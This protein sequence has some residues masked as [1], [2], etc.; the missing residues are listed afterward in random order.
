[1]APTSARPCGPDHYPVDDADTEGFIR[2]Y[3]ETL[4]HPVGTCR[5]GR[6]DTSVV[7]LSCACVASRPPGRRRIVMPRIIRGHTNARQS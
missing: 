4:Y 5:M 7:D 2:Q 3:S 6:D 1:M